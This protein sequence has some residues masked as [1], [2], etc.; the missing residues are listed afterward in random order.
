MKKER[1]YQKQSLNKRPQILLCVL[2]TYLVISNKENIN[3]IL[4]GP[5]MQQFFFSSSDVIATTCFNEI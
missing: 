3:K 4:M 1:Q 5:S 2:L